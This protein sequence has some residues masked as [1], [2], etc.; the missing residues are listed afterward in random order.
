[1]PEPAKALQSQQGAQGKGT[2][3]SISGQI[4]KETAQE[5]QK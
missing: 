1:M 2:E 4:A 3:L 5:F